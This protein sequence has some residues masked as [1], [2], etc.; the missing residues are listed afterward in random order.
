MHEDQIITLGTFLSRNNCHNYR[1]LTFVQTVVCKIVCACVYMRAHPVHSLK[2]CGPKCLGERPKKY[3]NLFTF[4]TRK[5]HLKNLISSK[6]AEKYN[7]HTV[8]TRSQ[9]TSIKCSKSQRTLFF[10]TF[11]GPALGNCYVKEVISI[12]YWQRR[13]ARARKGNIQAL[14]GYKRLR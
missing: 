7:K 6:Q 2:S 10:I 4:E 9:Y 11:F 1:Q 12:I 5:S 8:I 14:K 3:M 13:R